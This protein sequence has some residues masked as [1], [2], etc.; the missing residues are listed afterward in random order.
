MPACVAAGR[1]LHGQPAP[2][3]IAMDP[4]N[5]EHHLRR[6]RRGIRQRR[7]DARRRAS[8]APPTATTWSS[9]RRRPVP[10]SSYVNRLAMSRR[11]QVLLAATPSRRCSAART[12]RARTGRG[13]CRSASPMSSSTRRDHARRSLAA[14]DNGSAYFSTDG[15]ATWTAA[16]HPG[17]WSGRVE[18]TYARAERHHRLRLGERQRRRDLALHQRRPDATRSAAARG[19]DGE[20]ARLP[21]G[22][23]L[24]RQ[25][26]LGRRSDQRELRHR[27][28]HR[29]LAQ[30]RRRRHA[31]RHQHVVGSAHRPTPTTTASSR[32]RAYNGDDEPHACSSATTAAC[33]RTEDVRTVGNDAQLPRINGWTELVNTY[34]VTQ[35]YGGGRQRDQRGDHWRRPGQRHDLP[36]TRRRAARTGGRSSAATAAG[37]RLIRRIRTCSTASTSS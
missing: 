7:R 29:P 24:V 11:R 28:R 14:C 37:A 18:L 30:H 6:N 33:S 8:S 5:A 16:T 20:P 26:H 9:C 19:Q 12:P 23:G 17:I 25:R 32:T 36:A 15:G 22:P 13:A 35:F 34:G 1:R 10:T 3:C 27:R 31:H 4:T 21:R 2:C